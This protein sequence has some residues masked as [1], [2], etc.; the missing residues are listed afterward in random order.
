MSS[1]SQLLAHKKA[2]KAIRPLPEDSVDRG[3]RYSIAQRVQCLTL[4]T[5][6][7]TA[8]AIEEKLGIPVRTVRKIRKRAEDRGFN[9]SKDA[10]ILEHHVQD[11]QRTG[12][13]KE[14]DSS[15][16]AALLA[17]V[18]RDRN[19]RE[20]SSEVLAYEQSIS[21]S[22]ALRILHKYGLN[23]VKPTRKPGLNK[24]Q[25]AARLA[26]CLAHQHWTLE[27]F[28]NVIWSDETSVIMGQRRGTVRIWRAPDEAFDATVIRNRWKGF[29]EF[30]F[31][32]CFSYDK[33]GPCHIWHPETAAMKE[34]AQQEIDALNTAREQ[35]LKTEWE[36]TNGLRRLRVTRNV[37]GSKP[38]WRFNIKTGK[39]VRRKGNGI[40]WY[41]YWKVRLLT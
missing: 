11:G 1:A 16:E 35:E 10:R 32:G 2:T 24:A 12:R 28:K 20:K 26:F 21:Q 6:G 3:N 25:R 33:K 17:S 23:N 18:R 37:R 39:L 31:W 29:L 19:G 5:V 14:I 38:V 7:F 30:M 34:K 22:S 36:L 15:V 9:P 13:P 41:R 8:A 40:D 4:L 27:D